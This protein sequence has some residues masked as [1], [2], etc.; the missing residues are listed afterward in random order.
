ME[1]NEG[2]GR[3]RENEGQDMV[4]DENI[5]CVSGGYEVWLEIKRSRRRIKGL[6]G[7]RRWGVC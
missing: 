6:R 4:S 5:R 2:C 1:R 3:E 7:Q